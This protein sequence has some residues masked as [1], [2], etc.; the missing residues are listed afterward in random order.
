[1]EKKEKVVFKRYNL[2]LKGKD[3]KVLVPAKPPKEMYVDPQATV[4]M[5]EPY[6]DGNHE[7]YKLLRSISVEMMRNPELI[8]YVPSKRNLPIHTDNWDNVTPT[9]DV[10][11]YCHNSQLN[12][13][14]WKKVKEMLPYIKA[15]QYTSRYSVDRYKDY[16]EKE[17]S[18]YE[19]SKKYYSPKSKWRVYEC[20]PT[21]F[22]EGSR[23][24]YCQSFLKILEFTK[25]FN[26]EEILRCQGY[27]PFC[28]AFGFEL[29][30]LSRTIQNYWKKHKL[31]RYFY[32]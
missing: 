10:V 12:R 14:K 3:Y 31:G 16:C 2:R 26:F 7:M 6:L 24:L 5:D 22:V 18:A 20:P 32:I 25:E 4:Y 27:T 11:F 17:V 29:G 28:V 21:F 9:Y 1:M 15:V 30:Y 13:H 23:S 8:V 19:K